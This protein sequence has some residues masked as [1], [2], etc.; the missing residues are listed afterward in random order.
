MPLSFT[1]CFQA[2]LYAVACFLFTSLCSAQTIVVDENSD[3]VAVTLS[4]EYYE[5]SS[6][7]LTIDDVLAPS[8][9]V[10][11]I[12]HNRDLLNFGMTS[13]AYWV[14]FNLD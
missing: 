3:S 11:F 4:V 14:R 7:A 2:A 5:D 10:N 6:E 9:D 13:A 12:P 1:S 8:F